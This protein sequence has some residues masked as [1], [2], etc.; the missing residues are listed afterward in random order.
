M[1]PHEIR[2]TSGM[3]HSFHKRLMLM[4]IGAVDDDFTVADLMEIINVCVVDDLHL[5]LQVPRFAEFYREMTIVDEPPENILFAEFE[6]R[7]EIH[8][9][10]CTDLRLEFSGIGERG[11]T[12]PDGENFAYSLSYT[13]IGS[14]AHLP[15]RLSEEMSIHRIAKGKWDIERIIAPGYTLLDLIQWFLDDIGFCGSPDMRQ[16]QV[17]EISLRVRE[18]D[19]GEVKLFTQEEVMARLRERLDKDD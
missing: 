8:E 19:R 12:G 2:L 6:W 13:S 16:E 9:G 17:E 5:Y 15:I 14:I 11:R 7:L 1:L 4:D 18:I 3:H 10:R